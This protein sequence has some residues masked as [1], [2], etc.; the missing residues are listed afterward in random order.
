MSIFL[1][2][3]NMENIKSHPE[4][5]ELI[6]NNIVLKK[7]IFSLKEEVIILH[8]EINRLRNVINGNVINGND[9]HGYWYENSSYNNN[10]INN[11][12]NINIKCVIIEKQHLND[13]SLTDEQIR[14]IYIKYKIPFLHNSDNNDE[15][16][17]EDDNESNSEIST[18]TDSDADSDTS[19]DNDNINTDEIKL[20][21]I[22]E[23]ISK[24]NRPVPYC[25]DT[26]YYE[27]INGEDKLYNNDI[28]NKVNIEDNNENDNEDDEDDEV[29]EKVIYGTKYY[30]TRG[31]PSHIY[32]IKDDESAGKHVGSIVND[33]VHFK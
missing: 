18:S 10:K 32:E 21:Y 26:N 22:D 30:V 13:I 11:I 29:F 17:D 7:E 8:E 23:N 1:N 9:N 15:E 5:I 3:E 19:K 20:V 33:I 24:N 28:N 16:E 31:N 14:D 6:E 27:Y 4:Y 25:S 12:N 2:I